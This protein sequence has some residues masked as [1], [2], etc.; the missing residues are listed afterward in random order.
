MAKAGEEDKER[1]GA[2]LEYMGNHVEGFLFWR[3]VTPKEV[4]ELCRALVSHRDGVGWGSPEGCKGGGTADLGPSFPGK[5]R[6]YPGAFKVAR[7]VPV[8]KRGSHGVL[9][10]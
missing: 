2:F 6:V 7:V 3:P 1:D 10:L 9:Q 4:E 5:G 8:F